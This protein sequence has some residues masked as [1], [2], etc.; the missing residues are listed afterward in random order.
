MR[1][2]I[3][4]AVV[5][6]AIAASHVYIWARL[7]RDLS[8]SPRIRRAGGALLAVL[9]V[10]TPLAV[11]RPR[12]LGGGLRAAICAVGFPWVGFSLLLVTALLV[13]ELARA[14]AWAVRV[15][16]REAPPDAA[17]RRAVAQVLGGAAVAASGATALA[18]AAE[19][20]HLVIERV[21]V[22]L[23]RLPASM[24]GT[25]IVQISDVH[26]GAAV[27]PEYLSRVIAAAN[28]LDPDLV[29][30]TGDLVDGSVDR[31]GPQVALLR[32]LRARYGVFFV[33]GNH[34]Y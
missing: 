28:A 22:P 34:E 23:A 7:V 3:A 14:G 15:L 9:T 4:V 24:S 1:F 13:A 20:L 25:R 31:L 6:V 30:I 10:L 2:A 12:F 11:V 8:P 27:G 16:R 5:I 21:R 32:D 17:R 33:T 19:V 29:A 26:L 18:G